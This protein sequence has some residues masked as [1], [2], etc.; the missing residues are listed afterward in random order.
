MLQ[1]IASFN[2]NEIKYVILTFY[3]TFSNNHIYSQY[4]LLLDELIFFTL[5]HTQ[6]NKTLYDILHTLIIELIK[7]VKI[8]CDRAPVCTTQDALNERLNNSNYS[9]VY[10]LLVKVNYK[11]KLTNPNHNS[12]KLTM[13]LKQ[14]IETIIIDTL[15]KNYDFYS[16]TLKSINCKQIYYLDFIKNDYKI[17]LNNNLITTL[18][19]IISNN[20]LHW[21]KLYCELESRAD[22]SYFIYILI[23]YIQICYK[24]NISLD[25]NKFETFIRAYNYELLIF[26]NHLIV[27]LDYIQ[28]PPNILGDFY[29]QLLDTKPVYYLF[30]CK[31]NIYFDYSTKMVS[32]SLRKDPN[33]YYF[34]TDI[35][36]INKN[37]QSQNNNLNDIYLKKAYV[38]IILRNEIEFL[39]YFQDIIEYPNAIFHIIYNYNYISLRKHFKC[40]SSLDPKPK[41]KLNQ[42]HKQVILLNPIPEKEEEQ[43]QKQE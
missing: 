33:N 15:L 1:Y 19:C 10:A 27:D 42:K 11:L 22:T 38:Q 41:Q 4:F 25:S 14:Q 35:K 40:N 16:K 21:Y 7:Y 32:L 31:N 20:C 8:L 2:N 37:E 3:S 23:K 5:N 17:Y 39:L 24:Y 29:K 12:L 28:H 26:F 9:T 13:L 36:Y 30:K 43:K 34:I 6:S 18:E